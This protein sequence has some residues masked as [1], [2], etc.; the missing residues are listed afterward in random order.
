MSTHATCG[1]TERHLC[2]AVCHQAA[3]HHHLEAADHHE[4]GEHDKAQKHE[5][6]ARHFSAKPLAASTAATAACA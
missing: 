4:Q 5:E 1:T 3:A 2:A 6:S